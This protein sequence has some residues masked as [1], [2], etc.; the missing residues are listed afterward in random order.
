MT[1]ARILVLV[2]NLSVPFDRRVWQESRALVE[3]GHEVVV[4]CPR[5]ATQDT[6]PEVVLDGIRILRYPLRPATGGPSGYLREYGLALWHTARLAGR[7]RREGRVDVVH[8][9]NPPDLLLP[10]VLPLKF[11]GAK[12][13][14][15]H[16][17]LVPELFRSRFAGGGGWLL[18]MVLICERLTFALADGVISTNES[19]RQVAIDRGRKDPDLVQ[20]VRSAPDLERFTPLDADPG[21]RRGKRHLAAYLGVMGPQDGIDYALRALAHLHHDLGRND[22]HTIFMG[23]GDCFDEMVELSSRLGL[24]DC[25]EF[26]GRVPNEFVQRCLS[27]ADVCLAPDPLTPLNDVSSMNKIV[28]YMAIGRPIVAFDLVEARVSA[29]GAAVYAPANDELAFAKYIDELLRDP[30]RREEMGEMGRARAAGELSWAHSQRSLTEF[31][32]QI[33]SGAPPRPSR[34]GTP[35]RRGTT[36]RAGRLGWYAT[37]ARMMGPREIGWRIAMAANGATRTLAPR[38]RTR[39]VLAEPTGSSWERAYQSF[40]N[41]EDR[42]VVLDRARAAAIARELPE[43]ADAVVRAADAVLD[44]TFA[45]FGNPP[46]RYPGRIDWHLDPRDGFRWPD[47]PASRINHRTQRGD[48][49]WIWELNRLQHLPWFAQAW[50]FTGDD[51]YADAALDQLDSWLDQNPTGHGIAWR[52]GF[53]AGLRA[54]SVAIAVQGLRDSPAMTLE[55]Y[56]RI[57]TMLAESADLCWRDRSRFS[58]ANNHLLGEL[59]GVATVGILFPELAGA[60]RRERDALAAL[61]QEADRQI[62]PDGAGAEQSSAYLVFSAQLLLVPAALLQ[63]RGDRPPAA[64]RGAVRR[65]AG[66]LADLV[67]DGDPLPRY[68]DEDGGFAVRLHPEPVAT[69]ERHLA[70]V[71]ATVGGPRPATTGLPARWFADCGTREPEAPAVRTGSWYAPHGGV[72][73]V[74]RPRQRIMMDVGPLGYLSLAAHG[75]AD[76]LAVTI[77]ADGHDLIGDPGTGSYYAEPSWRN[78]FRRT[79]MHATVAVDDLDQSVA[80]GPFMWTRHAVT[81]VRGMDLARGVVEAEHDGYTRLDNPVRHRRY[82]VAPPDRDWALVLDLLDGT[83]RHRVRT[84][85]PLHPDLDVEDHGTTHMVTRAGGPVLQVASA[86]TAPVDLYRVRGDDDGLG[87]WSHRFESRTSAW[88]IGAVA[89]SVSGTVAIATVLTVSDGRGLRAE[90]LSIARDGSGRVDVTWTDGTTRP[91]VGIDTGT[92]GAVSYGPP[93]LA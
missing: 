11:L 44:G 89:E 6:E 39:G 42:P 60:Q 34:Q 57:V 22:L 82:L 65:S 90:D 51:T 3:A 85:W 77:A 73:V 7:V 32:T 40:R 15:D 63:L 28:E 93:V 88:L 30:R 48:A 27:T 91:A 26:T 38:A 64:I 36:P 75:H 1:R 41:G 19:Y 10:A 16:H 37:R 21:L 5:G 4:I 86:G 55:R 46:V 25:V 78:S 53:E 80:G 31:Y 47:I 83:G 14:F 68:G 81:S 8:A 67:G 92:P 35:G 13:V 58:S 79:R 54:I 43:E 17:D 61:A 66:Y 29:G 59:A 18:R 76:A 62:L 52:G 33:V 49:K 56:R 74:R 72:V 20:V 12:F 9:C 71:E 23:S 87:W 69:L 50:L 70:L 84:S 45:F 24:D 2:E